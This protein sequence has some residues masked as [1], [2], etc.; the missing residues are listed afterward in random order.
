MDLGP[1]VESCV[2]ITDAKAKEKNIMV[3]SEIDP[4]MPQLHADPLRVKQILINI[5]GNAVKFTPPKGRVK[6]EASLAGG[7]FARLIVSDNGGGMSISDIETAMRPFGQVDA[8]FNKR[9]EGTG[10]GLP[11]SA[12]LARLHG[13]SLTI[14]SEKGKGTR[15][16]ILLPVYDA[17]ASA[18]RESG[19]REGQA[20]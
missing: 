16:T 18:P 20:A 3:S 10:L 6:F 11:I 14:S 12:A 2:L 9:H 15:V 17:A 7:G 1:V 4:R 19:E 13:G 8:G 5:L